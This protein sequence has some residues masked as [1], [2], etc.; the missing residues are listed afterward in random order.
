MFRAG[1]DLVEV[2]F[3]MND[4]H[5]DIYVRTGLTFLEVRPPPFERLHVSDDLLRH[6]FCTCLRWAAATRGRGWRQASE[7]A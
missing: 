3:S 4:I 1:D 2:L 6:T 5:D 7:N